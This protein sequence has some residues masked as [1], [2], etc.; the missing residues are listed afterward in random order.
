MFGGIL[1]EN[2]PGASS[3]I[4]YQAAVK[5]HRGSFINHAASGGMSVFQTEC[6]F[7]RCESAF[8]TPVA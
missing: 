8:P 2:N 7:M 6:R 5:N 1:S 4:T 3:K